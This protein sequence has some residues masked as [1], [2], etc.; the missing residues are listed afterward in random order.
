[1]HWAVG[2]PLQGKHK[3]IAVS[4]NAAEVPDP[5]CAS[6]TLLV[7]ELRN[8][9]MEGHALRDF[10]AASRTELRIDNATK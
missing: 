2:S 1:M 6:E 8:M 4:L 9:P 10:A 5:A 7:T 3:N